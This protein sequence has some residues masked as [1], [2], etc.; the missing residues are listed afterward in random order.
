MNSRLKDLLSSLF[1]AYDK[2][3]DE[4]ISSVAENSSKSYFGT[5]SGSSAFTVNIPEFTQESLKDGVVISVHIPTF[6][7]T[8]SS[9]TLNVS[10]T[11]AVPINIA[12]NTRLGM[13]QITGTNLI[14]NFMYISNAWTIVGPGLYFPQARSGALDQVITSEGVSGLRWQYPRVLLSSSN[15]GAKADSLTIVPIYNKN[16][17]TGG[18]I[19]IGKSSNP[20]GSIYGKYIYRNGKEINTLY[21]P[22]SVVLFQGFADLPRTSSVQIVS[23]TITEYLETHSYYDTTLFKRTWESAYCANYGTS[24]TRMFKLKITY[25]YG[26]TDRV[27]DDYGTC[28]QM[29][30]SHYPANIAEVVVMGNPNPYKRVEIDGVVANFYVA[31]TSTFINDMTNASVDSSGSINMD[32]AFPRLLINTTFTSNNVLQ[33][34]MSS[35]PIANIHGTNDRFI[36]RICKI[37]LLSWT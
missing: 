16:F 10:G 31:N 22:K 3:V 36:I 30:K 19:G 5:A 18:R 17:D 12:Y 35:S 6:S 23:K 13:N 24:N 11:G 15:H 25:E 4:K 29:S 1:S 27:C 2:K 26:E 28:M 7:T 37:E 34:H 8:A 21:E 32:R 9:F 20:F 14:F 33:L